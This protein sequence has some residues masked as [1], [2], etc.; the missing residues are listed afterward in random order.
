MTTTVNPILRLFRSKDPEI[1]TL[2]VM[3]EQDYMFLP[4]VE[5]TAKK[6]DSAELLVIKDCGHVVNVEKPLIFN[7]LVVK[8]LSQ[9]ETK[10]IP[11]VC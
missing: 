1:P 5:M 4:P 6:H 8:W 11:A 3:G 9:L 10:K 7:E 2:Y